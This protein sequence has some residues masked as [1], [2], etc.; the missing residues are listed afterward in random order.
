MNDPYD[1]ERFVSA[2]DAD[3]T[4]DRAGAGLLKIG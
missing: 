4:F 1:L 3:G 2:Q